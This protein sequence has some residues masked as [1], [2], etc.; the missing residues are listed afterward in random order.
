MNFGDGF[1]IGLGEKAQD[2]KKSTAAMANAGA[3][4]FG[5]QKGQSFSAGISSTSGITSTAASS[6]NQTALSSLNK[7]TTQATQAGA[8]KGK[9]HSAGI[10]STKGAN[11]SAASSVSAT[12]TAQLAKTT[13]GGGGQKAGSQFAS[14]IRSQAGNASN[15]GSTV[16]Q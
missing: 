13:D 15:S 12:A 1:I 6:V 7:N 9:S 10:T 3:K 14:G 8:T 11:T 16:A 2:V 5:S 4:T